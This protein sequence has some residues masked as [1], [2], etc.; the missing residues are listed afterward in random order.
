MKIDYEDYD[1]E[2]YNRKDRR[3]KDRRNSGLFTSD[4]DSSWDTESAGWYSGATASSDAENGDYSGLDD[5]SWGSEYLSSLNWD[6][7]S[8]AS[9]WADNEQDSSKADTGR[10]SRESVRKNQDVNER[11]DDPSFQSIVDDGIWGS[12]FSDI[13]ISDQSSYGDVPFDLGWTQD[14]EARAHSSFTSKQR[15]I[16][17][18][19]KRRESNQYEDHNKR[20]SFPQ[21][22]FSDEEVDLA[23]WDDDNKPSQE[24]FDDPEISN[25][26]TGLAENIIQSDWNVSS[27]LTDNELATS[28]GIAEG[29]AIE[30]IAGPF[31]DFEG[32]VMKFEEGS[33]KIQA[34]IDVFGKQT[35]VKVMKEDIKVKN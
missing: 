15:S 7:S 33:D 6:D 29:V 19:E 20:K 17:K 35:M 30:V 28:S 32:V 26:T 23:W 5:A 25:D 9:N 14:P 12:S 22:T 16:M 10:K 13:N 24:S 21:K 18:G 31:K 11:V 34:E 8:T 3:K 4:S 1:E 2:V 27:Q